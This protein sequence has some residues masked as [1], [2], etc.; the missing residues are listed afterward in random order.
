MKPEKKGEVYFYI[1]HIDSVVT[2][3]QYILGIPIPVQKYFIRG[4][5]KK[6]CF[7]TKPKPIR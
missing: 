6:K 4:K 2:I 3:G 1:I 5:Q 7:E